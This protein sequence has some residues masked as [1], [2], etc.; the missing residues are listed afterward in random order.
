MGDNKP[1]DQSY[2]VFKE[3]SGRL[4]TQLSELESL[5]KTDLAALNTLLAKKKLD[6]VKDGVPVATKGI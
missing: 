3:L 6:A 2:V 1:T 4:D 5:A